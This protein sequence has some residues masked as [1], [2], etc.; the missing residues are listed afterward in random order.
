MAR[1]LVGRAR[2][3]DWAIFA[4]AVQRCVPTDSGDRPKP[5]ATLDRMSSASRVPG[6][7]W[8]DRITVVTLWAR[9]LF[10]ATGMVLLIGAVCSALYALVLIL[11]AGF[12]PR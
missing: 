6:G 8:T 4:G 2:C 7:P 5:S 3:R 10:A 12:G 9:R 1:H 11:M